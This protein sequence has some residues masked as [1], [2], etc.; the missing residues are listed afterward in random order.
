MAGAIPPLS[1][2]KGVLAQ[3]MSNHIAKVRW[4]K[5]NEFSHKGFERRHDVYFQDNVSLPCGGANNDYGADPE[6]MLASAMASCHMLTFL[7]LAAKK[8]L[9]VASYADDAEAILGKREDGKFWVE[10]IV[11]NPIVEFCGDKTPDLAT[12]RAMH[13]KAHAHCFIA[14]SVATDMKVEVKS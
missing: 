13:E 1:K 11:L 3:K 7:A 10:K 8:R 14:N 5:E 6:Q 9:Q 12:V 2:G 4:R